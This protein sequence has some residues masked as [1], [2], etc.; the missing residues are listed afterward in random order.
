MDWVAWVEAKPERWPRV[1][2]MLDR[3]AAPGGIDEEICV[4]ML[5][6]HLLDWQEKTGRQWPRPST[7]EGSRKGV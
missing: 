2:A 3:L 4:I 6:V 1:R 5:A 7:G